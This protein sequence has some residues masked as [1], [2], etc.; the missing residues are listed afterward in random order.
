ME[1]YDGI[2]KAMLVSL[3]DES[4][5]KPDK[6]CPM[7]EDGVKCDKQNDNCPTEPNHEPFECAT[8]R[9]YIIRKHLGNDYED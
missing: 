6:I 3:D 8:A 2:F 4:R 1:Y 9:R 5:I 7:L